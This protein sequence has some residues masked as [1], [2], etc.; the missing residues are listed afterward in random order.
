MKSNALLHKSYIC[1][2]MFIKLFDKTYIFIKFSC[3]APIIL[4]SFNFLLIE[5][6]ISF[7]IT[8]LGTAARLTDL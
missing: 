1:A 2:V 7:S 3:L 8:L 5:S 4:S 6:L